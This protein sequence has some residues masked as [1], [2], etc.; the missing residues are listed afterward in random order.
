MNSTF[1][2]RVAVRA[3]MG[4]VFTCT[5]LALC[6]LPVLA[7]DLKDARAALAGGDLDQAQRLFDR[8]TA[9]GFADGAAGVGLV[10]L[11]RRDYVKAQESFEKAQKMDPNNAMAWY[12][13]GEVRRRQEDY[14]KALPFLQKAVD[15]DRKFPDAQLALGDCLVRLKRYNEAIQALTPGLNW[16]A[17]WK[18]RFLVALGQVEMGRDSL[19]DAGIYFT[20]AQQAAPDDPATNRALGD[21]YLKRGIGSLAIP[22]YQKAV[23]LDS[24]DVELHFALGQALYFDQRYN[25][26]LDRFKWVVTKDPGYAPGQLALGN[27]YYLSGAADAKRYADAR[28]PLEKYTQLAPNDP[29]GWSLLGRDY[30][31]LKLKDEAV[32]AMTKAAGLGEKSKE[33]YTILGRC[34]VE[35]KN[36][37]GALEAYQK[38]EPNTTDLLKIGQMYVFLGS[39][40]KAD[41]VYRSMVDRDSLSWE[42]KFAL[43]EMGKLRFRQK[44]YPGTV[45]I[46][47]RRIALDPNSDEAYYFMG[48]SFNEMKQ[49]PDAAAALRQATLLAPTKA[50]RHFRLGLVLVSM[51][52]VAGADAEFEVTTQLDS[53][54]KDAAIAYRQLG[55]RA[56]LDKNWGHAVELLERSVAANPSDVQA[57]IW[58]AQGYAN[59]GNRTKAVE[60]FKK[61]L[62]VSPGNPEAT[63]GLKLLGN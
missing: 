41:S 37:N 40:D 20:Q 38:G 34:Y 43:V 33:M 8:V 45:G 47:Q 29:R 28:A 57:L 42:G 1:R 2:K 52:S 35:Q 31:F 18:P 63:K 6:A 7:D 9:Q 26:A 10:Q 59:A 4:L 17:K 5:A 23:E 19:R 51:D 61:V 60:T 15:L 22:S 25:D 46:L 58:L 3:L 21:F 62:I 53:T 56:L 39:P 11:R 13:Q 48:L 55:Y 16:G 27:L 14:E 36:W 24:A 12:G 32:A 50:D 44:D 49:L 54:S 30:Y